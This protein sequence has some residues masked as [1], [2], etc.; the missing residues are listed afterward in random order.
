M[1]HEGIIIWLE[2]QQK[3]NTERI[4]NLTI[5]VEELTKEQVAHEKENEKRFGDIM[6]VIEIHSQQ[7]GIMIWIVK[8]STGTVFLAVIG[9]I[10]SMVIKGG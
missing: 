6:T 3:N 2:V 10:L 4:E 5:D 8:L 9:A 7:I 1:S